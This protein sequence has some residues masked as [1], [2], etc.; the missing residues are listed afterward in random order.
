MTAPIAPARCAAVDDDLSQL[1]PA[2]R[3]RVCR[4]VED[5]MI[6]AINPL[7]IRLQQEMPGS[8]AADPTLRY[9]IHAVQRVQAAVAE[10]RA[11]AGE[12]PFKRA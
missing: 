1:A 2:D 11:L 10:I 3:L 7:A 8:I 5:R 12:T 6:N 9:A 4:W